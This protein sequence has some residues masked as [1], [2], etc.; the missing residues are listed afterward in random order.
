MHVGACMDVQ[1]CMD[2]W[3]VWVGGCAR[4]CMYGCASVYGC[5]VCVCVC[6]CDVCDDVV[7]AHA[8]EYIEPERY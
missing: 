6:M 4:G 8:T 5:V 1:V 3:C 2:V 7:E